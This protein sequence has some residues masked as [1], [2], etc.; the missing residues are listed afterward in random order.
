MPR[1]I[2]KKYLKSG[3]TRQEEGKK[4]RKKKNNINAPYV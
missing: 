4:R 3:T 2:E 1:G